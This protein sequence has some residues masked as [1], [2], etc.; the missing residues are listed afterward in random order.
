MAENRRFLDGAVRLRNF[1]RL[2]PRTGDA[3]GNS[4]FAA[5][6]ENTDERRELTLTDYAVEAGQP[7]KNW[8]QVFTHLLNRPLS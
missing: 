1:N 2:T 6:V 8:R 5:L 3:D 4:E 7:V